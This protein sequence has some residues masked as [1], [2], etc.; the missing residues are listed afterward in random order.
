MFVGSGEGSDICS[1]GILACSLV[2]VFVIWGVTFLG[3]VLLVLFFCGVFG[4]FYCWFYGGI[5][6]ILFN[7]SKSKLCFHSESLVDLKKN[8]RKLT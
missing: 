4:G 6:Y 2:C 8:S 5:N 3:G 7:K 1:T